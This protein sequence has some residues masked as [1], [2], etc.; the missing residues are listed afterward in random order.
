MD[1][2][3]LLKAQ[4]RVHSIHKQWSR[5]AIGNDSRCYSCDVFAQRAIE[6]Y[7]GLDESTIK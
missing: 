4:V 3:A 2:E 5:T 6:T 7:L 1:E